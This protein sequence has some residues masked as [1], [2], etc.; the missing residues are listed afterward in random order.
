MNWRRT[1]CRLSQSCWFVL[2]GGINLRGLLIM[3]FATLV[4][5]PPIGTISAKPTATG[6]RMTRYSLS[7]RIKLSHLSLLFCVDHIALLL[8]IN[9]LAKCKRSA[10]NLLYKLFYQANISLRRDSLAKS[11]T[12]ISLGR[13]TSLWRPYWVNH[14]SNRR[15]SNRSPNLKTKVGVNVSEVGRRPLAALINEHNA[16]FTQTATL[17]LQEQCCFKNG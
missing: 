16:Y 1:D 7:R 17:R 11:L 10:S 4:A 6:D 13:E 3:H 12:L 2:G 8:G 9:R 14:G 15:N 5:S